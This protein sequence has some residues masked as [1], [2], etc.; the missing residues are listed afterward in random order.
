[1][2]EDSSFTYESPS[3]LP[4]GKVFGRVGRDNYPGPEPVVILH[5]HDRSAPL[6]SVKLEKNS[7]LRGTESGLRGRAPGACRVGR[8][9]TLF[10]QQQ[11]LSA[12]RRGA[13]LSVLRG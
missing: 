9:G 5:R 8:G 2:S 10:G 1:M 6:V 12:L 4:L 13:R 11:P 3:N 7:K